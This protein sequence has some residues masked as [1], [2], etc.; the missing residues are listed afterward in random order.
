MI[1]LQFESVGIKILGVEIHQIFCNSKQVCGLPI[2]GGAIPKQPTFARQTLNDVSYKYESV[3]FIP[4]PP[5]N[6]QF[7]I[8]W[9]NILLKI[10][11]GPWTGSMG[12]SMDPRSMFCIRPA[13]IP[14]SL[15]PWQDRTPKL[16]NFLTYKAKIILEIDWHFSTNVCYSKK[17]WMRYY[18][19]EIL[20]LY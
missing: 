6:F 17:K 10:R 9:G 11:G 5:V 4:W 16:E 1:E 2:Y 14:A 20:S 15:H 3:I 13:P 19:V 8:N 7:Y 12:W 18:S